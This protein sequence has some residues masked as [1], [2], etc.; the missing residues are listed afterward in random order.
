MCEGGRG[1]V[2]PER[3]IE[4]ECVRVRGRDFR[5]EEESV[6]IRMT[7]MTTMTMMDERGWTRG[8]WN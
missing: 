6:I 7:M 8:V 1:D 5:H 3:R 2:W 4:R